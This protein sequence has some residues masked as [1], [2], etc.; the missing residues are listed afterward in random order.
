MPNPGWYPDPDGIGVQRYWDGAKW[1]DAVA[2]RGQPPP[3][4]QLPPRKSFW[5]GLRESPLWVKVGAVVIGLVALGG[6]FSGGEEPQTET[7]V[8][9]ER[10][11]YE[12]QQDVCRTEQQHNTVEYRRQNGSGD[13]EGY[14]EYAAFHGFYE[15]D[16]PDQLQAAIDGCLAGLHP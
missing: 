4:G 5:Q 11:I 10:T 3:P 1:T 15:V 12:Q 16:D 14:A 6:L 2:P 7:L 13:P 9:R 8:G